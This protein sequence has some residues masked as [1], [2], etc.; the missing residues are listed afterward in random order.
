M[1]PVSEASFF[2]D[3]ARKSVGE[4]VGDAESRTSA[5]IVVIVRRT[6]GTWREVDLAVGA[7][8]AFGVLLVLLFHPQPFA[9]EAMPVDV[10][11]AFTA[12]ALLCASLPPFKRA[13]LPR[14]GVAAQIRAKAREA[15][16]DQGVTRTRGRTGV[17]VYASMFERCVE[18]VVDVGVDGKLLEAQASALSDSVRRGPDLGAF[19]EAV[20]SMGPAL[21]SAL[22]RSEDDVNELPDAP[23]I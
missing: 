23:V 19:L 13:L 15:F 8:V 5:E 21:A 20:R 1:G 2:T 16:V 9:V 22:P 11:V 17:L 14:K 10:A 6:S 12:G 3:A 7:V 18:I 4:A